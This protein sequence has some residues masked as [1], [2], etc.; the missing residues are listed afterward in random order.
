MVSYITRLTRWRKQRLLI[1]CCSLVFLLVSVPSRA[2]YEGFSEVPF[3]GEGKS[4][5]RILTITFNP[6]SQ[7]N[8]IAEANTSGFVA[9]CDL[10]QASQ[11]MPVTYINP[12]AP[13]PAPVKVTG[14]GW[15]TFFAFAI[16]LANTISGTPGGSIHAV[17]TF[18]QS[19]PLF[20]EVG[21]IRFSY[22][23][24][25][26]LQLSDQL[27]YRLI[28]TGTDSD[29][30]VWHIYIDLHETPPDSADP[31][32]VH[33]FHLYE[34][35]QLV[36]GFH[37]EA[38]QN[39][40]KRALVEK[41]AK[42]KKDAEPEPP[43]P[44]REKPDKDNGDSASGRKRDLSHL[45]LNSYFDGGGSAWALDGVTVGDLTMALFKLYI[46]RQLMSDLPGKYL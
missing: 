1:Y 10:D 5:G 20:G 24:F 6:S 2:S 25:K 43:P 11:M 28:F 36:D 41:T 35:D 12:S 27:V 18:M 33:A 7:I 40:I 31:F 42:D 19:D 34:G 45:R 22:S 37:T 16:H 23:E 44:K 17:F 29:N 4:K 21:A 38:H 9:Y 8:L 39:V 30:T 26:T 32:M 3:Y 13:R 46:S 15:P 14:L